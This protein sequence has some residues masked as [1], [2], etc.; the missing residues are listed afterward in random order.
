MT[1]YKNM[2]PEDEAGLVPGEVVK[3]ADGSMIQTHN[4]DILIQVRG[5]LRAFGHSVELPSGV[6]VIPGY[7]EMLS[8]WICFLAANGRLPRRLS[9]GGAV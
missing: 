1:D 7:L 8:E 5:D 2:S 4:G 6:P 3:A 9:D